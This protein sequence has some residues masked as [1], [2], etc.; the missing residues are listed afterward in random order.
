VTNHANHRLALRNFSTRIANNQ[1]LLPTLNP[2]F[3]E[4]KTKI[5]FDSNISSTALFNVRPFI[6][7][8]KSHRY[9]PLTNPNIFIPKP[10]AVIVQGPLY[11]SRHAGF[12]RL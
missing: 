11:I 1:D 12:H 4:K 7:I 10:P 3:S 9:V 2:P 8:Q 5:V 6:A